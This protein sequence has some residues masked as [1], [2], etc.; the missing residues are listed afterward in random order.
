MKRKIRSKKNFL[1]VFFF[2]A[3]FASVVTVFNACQKNALPNPHPDG[4]LVK[5][6]QS[7]YTDTVL[8][9]NNANTNIHYLERMKSLGGLLEWSKA[10]EYNEN[11]VHMVVT[12][13]QQD[14]KPFQNK[15]YEAAQSLIFYIDKS[16]QMQLK[17]AELMSGKNE[18][19]GKDVTPVVEKA[20]LHAYSDAKIAA[21]D[22]KTNIIFL[23]R[24]FNSAESFKIADGTMTKS[25]FK[26]L[27]TSVSNA[28][29]G[30][31]TILSSSGYYETWYLLGIWY[32]VDTGEVVSVDVLSTYQQC[33][34]TCDQWSPVD[35]PGGTGGGSINDCL[36]S[37]LQNV[38]ALSNGVYVTSEFVSDNVTDAGNLKK[39]RNPDWIVLKGP[40]WSLHSHEKGIVSLVDAPTNKWQWESLDHVN[41]TMAGQTYGG[42]L[43]PSAGIGTPSFVPGTPNIL[44]A[45]MSV[46]FDVTFTPLNV[47]QAVNALVPAFTNN[48]T[49]NAIFAAKPN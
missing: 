37:T 32:D 44:Y 47:C 48:Y 19:L 25:N 4:T 24:N 35:D 31:H 26:L 9:Q 15:A 39:Y 27:N 8:A 30:T 6:A 36:N 17:I 28:G 43:S 5:F 40:G 42:S 12:P 22:I 23:N 2:L 16:G 34:G 20:F 33:V 3:T 21:P 14:A 29:G 18:S 38:S 11:G 46:D 13:V 49:A 45:G 41:I 1:T 7:W 10:R